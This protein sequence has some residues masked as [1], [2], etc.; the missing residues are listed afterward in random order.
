MKVTI[1]V[2]GSEQVQ[3]MLNRVRKQLED[4][5]PEL[6]VTGEYLKGFYSSVPFETEG[7]FFGQRWAE[8]NPQYVQWKRR[9][10]PGRGILEASGKLRRSFTFVNTSTYLKVSNTASYFPYHQ[11]GGQRLPRRVMLLMNRKLAQAVGEQIKR[12]IIRRIKV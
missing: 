6:R 12:S 2:K 1:T 3:A 7:S 9:H 4:F 10:Y 11:L 8:L 5:S